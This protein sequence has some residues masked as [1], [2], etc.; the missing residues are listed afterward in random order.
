MVENLPSLISNLCIQEFQIA[1]SPDPNNAYP[2][3]SRV[4]K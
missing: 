3:L 1:Q 4:T 2:T